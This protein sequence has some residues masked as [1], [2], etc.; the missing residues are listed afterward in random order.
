MSAQKPSYRPLVTTAFEFVTAG[1]LGKGGAGGSFLGA[2]G[3]AAIFKPALTG[4]LTLRLH[5]LLAIQRNG[6]RRNPAAVAIGQR[7]PRKNWT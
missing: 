4:A 2:G 6:G 1:S 3:A 7:V 5:G